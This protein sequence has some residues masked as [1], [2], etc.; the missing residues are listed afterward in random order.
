ML[1]GF[2]SVGDPPGGKEAGCVFWRRQQETFPFPGKQPVG[3]RI[4]HVRGCL[5]GS[6][7]EHLPWAQDVTPGSRDRVPHRA[8]R[9]EPASPSAC[10]CLSLGLR[11]K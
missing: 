1:C 2:S 7:A 3:A 8:P 5:G 10:L 9:T 6:V 4:I 11:N